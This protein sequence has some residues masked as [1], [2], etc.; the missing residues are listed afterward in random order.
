MALGVINGGLGLQLARESDGPV[1]AYSVVAGVVFFCYTGFKVCN[2]FRGG[3][4]TAPRAPKEE[5]AP[6]P[7][8]GDQFI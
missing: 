7:R 6:A 1:I 8:A 5:P 3:V 2:F 4:H